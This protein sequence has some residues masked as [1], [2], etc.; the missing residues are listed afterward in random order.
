M[1]QVCK[2]VGWDGQGF[3]CLRCGKA[4]FQSEAQARGHLAQCRGRAI[5]RGVFHPPV[6]TVT[7]PAPSGCCEQVLPARGGGVPTPLFGGAPGGGETTSL[8]GGYAT[9]YPG[10]YPGVDQ[11]LKAL[12]NEYNHLLMQRNL[13]PTGFS[14]GDWFFQN[15]AVVIIS[16]VAL[17]IYLS[18]K[19]SECECPDGKAGR[20]VNR[21]SGFGEKAL[22]KLTDRAITKTI[23]SL[24]K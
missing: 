12:E 11:R 1:K 14:I 9:D 21:A 13:Q 20:R 16:V 18:S 6:G 2:D 5:E 3:C 15:K 22:N 23:D 24:L 10:W 4:G 7:F 19:K 8:Q 17:M